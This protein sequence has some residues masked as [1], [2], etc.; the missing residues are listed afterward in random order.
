[1]AMDRNEAIEEVDDPV[2]SVGH[3]EDGEMTEGVRDWLLA[4]LRSFEVHLDAIRAGCD[5]AAIPTGY[6]EAA[7]HL[8]EIKEK[9]FGLTRL[10]G[11]L[12]KD[13]RQRQDQELD[14]AM[15]SVSATG[16]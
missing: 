12:E 9:T 16:Y 2:S 5:S 4:Q 15:E 1:M 6:S 3:A 14:A 8:T 13:F 11:K 7:N 10:L